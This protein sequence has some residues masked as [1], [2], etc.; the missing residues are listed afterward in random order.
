MMKWLA[1]LLMAPALALAAD[2]QLRL[3][4]APDRSNDM[5]ALQNGAKLFINYCLNCHSAS[6]MRYNR[7]R[8]VGLSDDQIREKLMFTA[9]KVGELMRI[10]LQRD[11]AKAWFGV[12]P[13]I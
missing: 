11:E 6:Y 5:H 7:L 8:D 1:I 10:A 12:A 13:L 2:A 3:D 9:D 4:R